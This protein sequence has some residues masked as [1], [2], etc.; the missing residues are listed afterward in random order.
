M[1]PQTGA[2]AFLKASQKD[3]PVVEM[4]NDAA[5]PTVSPDYTYFKAAANW[6]LLLENAMDP[7]HAAALHEGTMGKRKDMVGCLYTNPKNS[8]CFRKESH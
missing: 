5:L 6:S 3:P 4:F 7:T 8:F 2:D 1:W